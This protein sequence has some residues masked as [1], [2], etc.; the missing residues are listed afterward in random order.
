MK[1]T[2]IYYKAKAKSLTCQVLS[3]GHCR[4]QHGNPVLSDYNVCALNKKTSQ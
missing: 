3:W 4:G 2:T 1:K